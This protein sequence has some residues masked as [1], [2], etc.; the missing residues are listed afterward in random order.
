MRTRIA[1][2]TAGLAILAGTLAS[3]GSSHSTGTSADPAGVVP[4]SAPVYVGAVVRPEGELRAAAKTAG[5]KLTKQSDPYLRLLGILQTPGS[6]APDFSREIAPW[7]G[8]NAGLFVTSL[9]SSSALT[10]LLTQALTSG[11]SSAAQWPFGSGAAGASGAIVLDASNLSAARTFVENVASRAHAH[12]AA[13][14]GV[15]YQ[16]TAGGDAFAIVGRF[17]VLGTESGIHEVIETTQGGAALKADPAYAHLQ[18]LAPTGALGHVYE[19]PASLAAAPGGTGGSASQL[20]SLLRVLGGSRPLNVSLVPSSGSLALDADAGPA[21][22]GATGPT[23]AT[24]AG[25]QRDGGLVQAAATGNRAFGELPGGSW[26]AAGFGNVGTAAGGSLGAVHDLLSLI[27][28]LG[29]GST[30]EGVS[31]PVSLSV[32]G[33][34]EGLLTPLDALSAN[35]PQAKHDFLGWMGEAG[36]FAG[37]TTIVEL[38]GGIVIDSTDPA[39]S[40]AAVAELGAALSSEGSEAT[41]ASVPGTEAAIEAKVAGLPITLVIA[42]GRAANGQAKFVLGL[43]ASSIQ[44]ALRPQS[45]MAGSTAYD[46]ARSALG[47]GIAPSIAVSFP[48]MLTL[49]EGFGLGEDPTI[50]PVLPYLRDSSTLAG[51]GKSLGGEAERLRLVLGLQPGSG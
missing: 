47:E 19:N 28:S 15:S 22:T 39:A 45:T 30:G 50:S 36:V 7:L 40:R 42:D 5:E 33:L 41:P 37:G 2:T 24:T 31:A 1:A 29:S 13:Y 9:G 20:P 18:S 3:C 49:L 10:S 43:A 11:G 16:A 8:P 38:K 17:V 12:D 51:G 48:T 25:G 4:A 23:G 46:S 27:G 14:R 21:P 34:L 32:K 35:T 26:L 6:K 44:A